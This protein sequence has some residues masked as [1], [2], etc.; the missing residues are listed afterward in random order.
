MVLLWNYE[1]YNFPL[2]VQN[3]YHIHFVSLVYGILNDI[4]HV[5]IT[6]TDTVSLF[7]LFYR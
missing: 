5:K 3:M 6:W 1:D 4:K 2:R 7:M